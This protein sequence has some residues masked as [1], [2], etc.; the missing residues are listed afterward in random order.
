MKPL[1]V[2]EEELVKSMLLLLLLTRDF[3]E[4]LNCCCRCVVIGVTFVAD[5]VDSFTEALLLKLC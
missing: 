2:D 3:D 4:A 1:E 5:V